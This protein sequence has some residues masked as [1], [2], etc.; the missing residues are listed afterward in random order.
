MSGDGLHP[1]A[2]ATASVQIAPAPVSVTALPTTVSYGAPL[3]TLNGTMTGVLPQ[4]QGNVNVAFIAT[5]PAMPP[6]GSY[7]IS[8]SLTGPASANYTASLAPNSGSLTVLPAA[9]VATLTPAAAAYATLPLQLTARIAST[10]SGIPTGTVQF[11]DGSTVIA[12][13]PLV[14]GSASAVELNPASGQHSF[15]V[16]YSGDANFRTST[17]TP[18]LQAINALPDFTVALAGNA[19]QTVIAGAAAN[20][21]PDGRIARITVHGSRHAQRQ[22]PADRLIRKLLSAGG[23]AWRIDCSGHHDGRN[24]RCYSERYSTQR[25]DY[26]RYRNQREAAQSG[27]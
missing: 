5:A 12:T 21:A 27:R 17:S 24:Q 8:A 1:S 18:V 3:P 15:S 13:A 11:L 26:Q 23:C 2:T 14:N 25:G 16:A 19:Q 4:D 22:R 6:V 9:T 10:T 7:P 20:Y